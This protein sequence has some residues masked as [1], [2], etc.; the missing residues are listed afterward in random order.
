M[1]KRRPSRLSGHRG[2]RL[3]AII[4]RRDGVRCFHCGVPFASTDEAT[5][6][7]FVPRSVWCYDRMANFVLAC[8]PCNQAKADVLPLG[9]LLVLQPWLTGRTQ[10]GRAA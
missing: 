4:G 8:D 7:H 5:L 2:R 1:S 6:D 3:R 10:E 9:L